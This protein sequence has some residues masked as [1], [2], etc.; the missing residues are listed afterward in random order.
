MTPYKGELGRFAAYVRTRQSAFSVRTYA[1]ID[2][3][4]TI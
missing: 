4:R 1:E 2:R 3:K